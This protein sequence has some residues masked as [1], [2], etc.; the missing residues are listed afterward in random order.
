MRP[1]DGSVQVRDGSEAPR[2]RDHGRATERGLGLEIVLR[3]SRLFYVVLG[4]PYRP[5][6]SG[7][8][9]RFLLA[10][11]TLPGEIFVYGSHFAD[12]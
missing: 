1:S 12:I 10:P 4:R 7:V 3:R 2:G 6:C 9:A 5:W 11:A 8:V